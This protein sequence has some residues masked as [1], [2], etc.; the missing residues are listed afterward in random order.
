[1]RVLVINPGA[2]STKVAVYSED[3]V[4]HQ[5]N[6]SHPYDDIK[7]F[8][9]IAD[10]LDYRL[11]AIRSWLKSLGLGPEDFVAV[12]GR[13]GLVR[14][15][16]SGT[17]RVDEYAIQDA[18][19]GERQHPANLGI[20]L[21]ERLASEAGLPAFFTDPVS[22][23]EWPDFVHYSGFDGIERRC[24]F[25]ALNQKAMARKAAQ[26]LNKPYEEAKLVVVHLG[27]GVS[28]A[29]HDQG[30]VVDVFNVMDEGAFAL[31]RSGSIPVM[32]LVDYC[33]SGRTKQEVRK[34]LQAEG[35]FLSYLGTQD[36]REIE[37]LVLA[38]DEKAVNVYA[39]FL[40]QLQKDIGAMAAVLRFQVDG[41]VLT[42]GMAYSDMLA[43]DLTERIAKLARVLRLPGEHE[44]AALASGAFD[45]LKQGGKTYGPAL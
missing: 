16:E 14:H 12:T 40:W 2:T 34:T 18:L 44:M 20:V 29:A 4:L 10:Q 17:Y 38:H 24:F 30:R 28:V 31:N 23:D 7:S 37:A 9:H 35:G 41:I 11:A 25:H 3:G 1:M 33:F 15:I 6:L 36:F 19:Y 22:V 39:A 21:S 45:A 26:I 42:G 32:G 27:G 8:P 5:T 43:T 13:G